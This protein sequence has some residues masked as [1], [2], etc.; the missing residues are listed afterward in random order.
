[1]RHKRKLYI[2]LLIVVLL[3]TSCA[4][5]AMAKYLYA[6]SVTGTVTF[7]T[8]LAEEILLQESKA[9]R[10]RNGSYELSDT[11]AAENVYLAMP[12]V[13]IPK[14]PY[15]LITEKSAVDAYLYVEVVEAGTKP[16]TITY[17]LSTDWK[18]L[19][20]AEAKHGG[21]VYVYTGGSEDAQIL[22]ESFDQTKVSI[23]KDNILKVS[24]KME[25]FTEFQLQFYGYMIQSEGTTSAEEAY[26]R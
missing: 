12:G 26:K 20:G 3:G 9:E 17:E 14:D 16:G 1:M 15:F 22:N 24:E 11:P 2:G 6:K 4:G 18:M 13:D 10:R 19:S 7:S 5:T 8:I 25:A 21:R 23:L